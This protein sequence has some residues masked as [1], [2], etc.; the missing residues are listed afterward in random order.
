M[1][2]MATQVGALIVELRANAVQFQAEM[3]TARGTLDRTGGSFRGA[4]RM[5]SRFAAQGLGAVVPGAERATFALQNVIQSTL[6]AGGALR[7]LGQAGIIGGGVLA[8]AAGVQ[9]LEE[10]IRNW[11]R[12][13][14]T[15]TQ[16]LDRMKQAAEEQKKFADD[17]IRAV[18]LQA[19]LE[20]QLVQ[21]RGQSAVATLRALGEERSAE[22]AA[23]TTRLELIERERMERERGIIQSIAQ[24]ARRD[25]ALATNEAVAFAA[26]TT[27]GAEH[28]ATVRKIEEA[29]TQKQFATWKQETDFLRD[30]LKERVQA[31]QQFE[32]QRGQGAAGLGLATS[33]AGGFAR[34][35]QIQESIKKAAADQAFLEREGLISPRDAVGE[36]ERLRQAAVDSLEAFKHEFAG[37][38]EAVAAA[39]RAVDQ[40]QFSNFGLQVEQGRQWVDQFIASTDELKIGVD[41][42][43]ERLATAIKGGVDKAIPEMQRFAAEVAAMDAWIRQAT[44]DVNALSGALGG[45]G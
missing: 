1:G 30:Q 3:Q 19:G 16:T 42:L 38:P 40:I 9:W 35:R 14:E 28:D 8:V 37:V 13:G 18:T 23:L 32:A 6:R 27:A 4:E 36:R 12:L 20:K 31:R 7:V 26:R 41:D 24:G 17:R 25:Q 15:V 10:N 22:E 43:G 11:W 34:L 5:A 39:Q 33:A 45:G 21:L 29:A 44:I 2:L